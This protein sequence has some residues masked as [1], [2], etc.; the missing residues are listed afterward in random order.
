MVMRCSRVV[1]IQSASCGNGALRYADLEFLDDCQLKEEGECA[2]HDCWAVVTNW[3][4]AFIIDRRS[5]FPRAAARALCS[6]GSPLSFIFRLH[7]SV[8]RIFQMRLCVVFS[9]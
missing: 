6:S 2:W 3:A 8:V 4:F 9:R 1:T 7:L 5:V